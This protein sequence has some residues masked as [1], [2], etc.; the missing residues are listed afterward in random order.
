MFVEAKDRYPDT[1]RFP[2]HGDLSSWTRQGVLL[3]NMCLTVTP[4]QP[5]SHMKS[6][7]GKGNVWGPFLR[8]VIN[9]IIHMER[10]TYNKMKVKPIFVL[11][12]G[13]AQS[14]CEFINEKA[15]IITATHPSPMSARNGFF[16]SQI[17]K[18][19]NFMLRKFG[20]AEIDWN[21]D[22]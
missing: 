18:K 4:G 13:K 7:G 3:L 17:F 1:F 6:M 16:G 9:S 15:I 2:S 11:L 22:P 10:P 5:E 19:V 21:L 12:G 8:R 20:M 14:I